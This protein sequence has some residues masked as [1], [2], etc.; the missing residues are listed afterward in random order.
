[1]LPRYCAARHERTSRGWLP[2][3]PPSPPLPPARVPSAPR[4]LAGFYAAPSRRILLLP[5]F[6]PLALLLPLSDSRT[7]RLSILYYMSGPKLLDAR[8]TPLPPYLPLPFSSVSFLYSSVTYSAVGVFFNNERNVF[9]TSNSFTAKND[10]PRSDTKIDAAENNTR[11][12]RIRQNLIF[13]YNN[14]VS[15]LFFSI[16]FLFY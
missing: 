13:C 7:H 2:V 16:Y 15:S 11:Q 4:S 6:P 3:P 10:F 5:S 12:I 9:S 8:T 1:M 14:I